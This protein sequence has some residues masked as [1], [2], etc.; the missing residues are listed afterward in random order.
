MLTVYNYRAVVKAALTV[1]FI[2]LWFALADLNMLVEFVETAQSVYE[3]TWTSAVL[4]RTFATRQS[5][6]LC[7]KHLAE[8]ET[9]LASN[10]LARFFDV[11]KDTT[12]LYLHCSIAKNVVKLVTIFG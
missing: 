5:L 6:H 7:R 9:G 4:F 12:I 8:A 11:L 10:I 3:T 1:V 2:R